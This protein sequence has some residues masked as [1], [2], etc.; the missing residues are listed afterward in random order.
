MVF[1]GGVLVW[2]TPL[3]LATS[4]AAM[5][6]SIYWRSPVATTALRR[7]SASLVLPH[8]VPFK[9]G[10]IDALVARPDTAPVSV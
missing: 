1:A 8:A 5:L 6:Y 7:C 10:A 2:A 4:A 9:Q 3:S